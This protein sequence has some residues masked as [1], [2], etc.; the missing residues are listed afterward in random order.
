MR[1]RYEIRREFTPYIGITFERK[2]GQTANM[3]RAAGERVQSTSFVAG[4]K[5]FF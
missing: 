4:V 3:T 5:L 2:T 1:L